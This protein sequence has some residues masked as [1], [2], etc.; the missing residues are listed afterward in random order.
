MNWHAR[1]QARPSPMRDTP[2]SVHRPG[3]GAPP[4]SGTVRPIRPPSISASILRIVSGLVD[5]PAKNQSGVLLFPNM[6]IHHPT[7]SHRSSTASRRH[8]PEDVAEG[9][10]TRHKARNPIALDLPENR[11]R[12][13]GTS[14]SAHLQGRQAD[15]RED[16]RDDP[17]ADHD[18]RLGPALFLVMMMDR[19]HQEDALAGALEID[20]LNDHRERLGHEEAA[21]DAQNQFVLGGDRDGT[22]CAAQGQRAGIAHEDRR[23]GGVV[24]QEAETAAHQSRHE[25][26]DL[27]GTGHVMQ[28][29]IFGEVGPPHRV[30][31]DA[32]RAEAIITGM[33]ASPSSP[34]V[35][36]TALAAPTTTIMAKGMKRKP[37]LTSTS[38]KT[39]SAS[40]NCNS[41]GW[42]QLAQ[43]AA[44]SAMRK[45]SA[46]RTRPG[47]PL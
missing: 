33:I 26:Q 37:R 35:R 22:Q 34:S 21:D 29:E 25:D 9:A 4:I 36:L 20:H 13:S 5:T 10:R 41:A 1:P 19:R 43:P 12:R 44:T 46:R 30:G 2:Q 3:R 18:L 24:P 8:L 39:G 42:C 17:E 40:W 6:Q 28:A 27:A 11:F 47:T 14:L 31:D 32:E 15:Q 23:R 45:P 38:L 16:E 7:R